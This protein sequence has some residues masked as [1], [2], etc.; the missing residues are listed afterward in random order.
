MPHE[1][2]RYVA[3]ENLTIRMRDRPPREI[4]V[5]EAFSFE[6]K[7]GA[8]LLPIN[9]PARQ[10]KLRAIL[11]GSGPHKPPSAVR[12]AKSIGFT[13]HDTAEARAFIDDFVARESSRQTTSS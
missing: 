13:G 4:N 6:G 8:A 9:A 11:A 1:S 12:L 7:P 5:G 3:L 2:A 10:N